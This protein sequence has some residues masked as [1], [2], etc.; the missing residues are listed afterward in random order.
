MLAWR[1]RSYWEGQLGGLKPAAKCPTS[2]NVREASSHV[3]ESI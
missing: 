1:Q 2:W 3:E